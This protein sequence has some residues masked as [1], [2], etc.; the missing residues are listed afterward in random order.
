MK[1]RHH[2]PCENKCG[3]RGKLHRVTVGGRKLD[4]CEACL[5]ALRNI[6]AEQEWAKATA[7]R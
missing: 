2:S 6:L 1:Q 3:A 4:L 7:A 5:K